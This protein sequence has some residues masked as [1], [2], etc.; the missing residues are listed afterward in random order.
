MMSRGCCAEPGDW[1]CMSGE[2]DDRALSAS[3]EGAAL[4]S[5]ALRLFASLARS[6]GEP[7]DAEGI[8]RIGAEILEPLFHEPPLGPIPEYLDPH[9]SVHGCVAEYEDRLEELERWKIRVL[10]RWLQESVGSRWFVEGKGYEL[11][12]CEGCGE[13][14]DRYRLRE[15]DDEVGP[16]GSGPSED[17]GTDGASG[18]R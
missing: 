6:K 12:T 16:A 13:G 17:M 3:R 2:H 7:L 9:W 5:S 18:N 15:I 8:L 14:T 4:E 1:G 11:Q 10:S